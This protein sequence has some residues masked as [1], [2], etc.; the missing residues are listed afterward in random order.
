[1]NRPVGPTEEFA[2]NFLRHHFLIVIL[3]W[4]AN[5]WLLMHTNGD[6]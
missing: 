2:G 5:L 6:T 3:H 1:V 4:G